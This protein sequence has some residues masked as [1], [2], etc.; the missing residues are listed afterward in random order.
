MM[1]SESIMEDVGLVNMKKRIG[2]TFE[3]EEHLNVQ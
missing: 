1:V 3:L 2:P